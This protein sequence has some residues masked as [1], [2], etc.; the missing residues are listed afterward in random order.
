MGY[1]GFC[2]REAFRPFFRG[3]HM[4]GDKGVS[5]WEYFQICCFA[6]AVEKLPRR[7]LAHPRFKNWGVRLYGVC[8][9]AGVQGHVETR[10]A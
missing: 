2:Q 1:A 10:S 9:Q 3:T 7:P 8:P 4:D 6:I 5:P